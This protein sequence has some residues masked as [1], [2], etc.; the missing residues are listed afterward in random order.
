MLFNR[1]YRR[2]F[3]ISIYTDL[4]LCALRCGTVE[5]L[6]RLLLSPFAVQTLIKKKQ[7][8]PVS[9]SSLYLSAAWLTRM[10]KPGIIQKL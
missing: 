5:L 3:N 1:C 2:Y 8:W 4:L 10:D 9:A 6:L 7:R